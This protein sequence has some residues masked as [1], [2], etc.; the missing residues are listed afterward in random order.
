[1]LHKRIL[2]PLGHRII[3]TAAAVFICKLIFIFL[4]IPGGIGSS[5]V[6][7]IICMQPYVED[8]KTFA[9]DRVLGT[10]LGAAWSLS[11]LVLM[12]TVSGWC[13]NLLLAD[14]LM[15]LFV[16]ASI[17]STVIIKKAAIASLVAIV[18]VSTVASYPDVDAPLTQT[19]ENLE[20]T[21]VGTVVAVWVNVAHLPRK[22]NEDQLFFVRTMDL[23]PDRFHQIPSSVHI[24]LDHLYRDGARICLVS[25]WAPAFVISQMGLL[26]VNAPMIIMDGAALYDIRENKYLDVIQMPQENADRLRSILAGFGV[27]CNIYTVNERTMTIYRDGPVSE[28]EK[29]EFETMRRSPYRNYKDGIYHEEDWIAFIRVIDSAEKIGELAYELRSVLPAGMFRMEVREEAHFPGLRGI[30]FYD[31][32]ATVSE[33]KKRTMEIM[34]QEA[35]R[36]LT[37]VDMLPRITRYLPEHDALLLLSRLKNRYEPVWFFSRRPKDREKTECKK[38]E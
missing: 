33:M 9:L 35:G 29:T 5:A 13:P 27:G 30:Y 17:Y 1:M 3:K 7:A 2:P 12:R 23:V 20:A 31:F 8:S 16:I 11:Y 26:K 37:S 32:R 15:A 10:V 6:T 38:Q 25:R 19:L 4:N 36:Q 24:A 14:V 22:K 28:A 21:I 34:E 18:L